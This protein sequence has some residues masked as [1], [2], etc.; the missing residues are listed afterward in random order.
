MPKVKTNSSAAKRLKRTK[1]GKF[2]RGMAFAR[3]LMT[4]KP[5]KRRRKLRKGAVLSPQDTM[6]AKRMLPYS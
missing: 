2:K 3:H 4:H 6:R 5:A 1:N